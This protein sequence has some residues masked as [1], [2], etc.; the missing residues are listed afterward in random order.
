MR[1]VSLAQTDTSSILR[2]LEGTLSADRQVAAI[3]VANSTGVSAADL[4]DAGFA[5]ERTTAGEWRWI[6]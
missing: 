2:A 3:D 5:I 1:V 4:R 6:R